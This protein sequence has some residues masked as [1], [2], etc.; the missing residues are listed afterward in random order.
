M[1]FK[2]YLCDRLIFCCIW[3]C[4]D[5]RRP[6]VDLS[7]LEETLVSNEPSAGLRLDE[8]YLRARIDCPLLWGKLEHCGSLSQ[9]GHRVVHGR[10]NAET[11]RY[12]RMSNNNVWILFIRIVVTHDSL[13]LKLHVLLVSATSFD[14]VYSTCIDVPSLTWRRCRSHCKHPPNSKLLWRLPR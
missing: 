8:V 2:V 12:Y 1:A 3:C 13:S 14:H 9:F 11:F 7:K 5:R 6:N 4:F 10:I